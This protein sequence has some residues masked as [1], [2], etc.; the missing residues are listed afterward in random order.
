MICADAS[1]T[2][3]QMSLVVPISVMTFAATVEIPT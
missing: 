1:P 3:M 2:R